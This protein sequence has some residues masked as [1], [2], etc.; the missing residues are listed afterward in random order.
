MLDKEKSLQEESLSPM[1]ILGMFD[2]PEGTDFS[3]EVDGTLM[4]SFKTKVEE[5]YGP[6]KFYELLKSYGEE[7]LL[8]IAIYCL[9]LNEAQREYILEKKEDRLIHNIV[10]II[11][12]VQTQLPEFFDQSSGC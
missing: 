1:R 11:K 12:V 6:Q 2:I 9:N 4:H 10:G 7:Q 5:K 3:G 8:R